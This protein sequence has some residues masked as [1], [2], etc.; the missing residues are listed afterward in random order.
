MIVPFL[1]GTLVCSLI[2]AFAYSHLKARRLSGSSWESLLARLEAV[3]RASIASVA[4]AYLNP[5]PHQ[6]GSEPQEFWMTLGGFEGLLRMRRNAEVLIALA[7]YA[8]RWNSTEGVIVVERMRRDAEMLK[9]AVLHIFLQRLP[10]VRGVRVP[11][12][13][14]EAATGY[15]LMTERLLALY[16]TSHAGLLPRLAEAL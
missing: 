14:H 4:I 13:L 16:Q 1:L 9:M 3:P 2:S 7:A 11:F 15:Y 5:A 6:L 10:G 8:E 12:F